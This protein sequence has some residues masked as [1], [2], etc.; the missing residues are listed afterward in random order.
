MKIRIGPLFGRFR[1]SLRTLLVMIALAS[2][3]LAI[4][5]QHARSQRQLVDAVRGAGGKVAYGWETD[6]WR[7]LGFYPSYMNQLGYDDSRY[8]PGPDFWR[9]SDPTWKR[10]PNGPMWIR[11]LLGDECFENVVCVRI[12]KNATD[13]L[14]AQIGKCGSL[15]GLTVARPTGVGDAGIRALAGLRNLEVLLLGAGGVDDGS[16]AAL[17]GLRKLRRLELYYM[18][19]T[20]ASAKTLSGLV[21]LE[22][23]SLYGCPISDQSVGL[24]STLPHLNRLRIWRTK[25]TP[26][27]FAELKAKLPDSCCIEYDGN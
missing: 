17:S 21:N 20:D 11:S 14:L 10:G 18:P 15:R 23:L 8:Y 12:D 6:P 19:I 13:A 16:L 24:L 7:V 26:K 25:I 22:H 1:F 5:T 4:F 3:P 27:G 9:T 2:V